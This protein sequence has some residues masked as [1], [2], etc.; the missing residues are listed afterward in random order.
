MRHIKKIAV[1]ILAGTA[2]TALTTVDFSTGAYAFGLK[3]LNPVSV[4][5]HVDPPKAVGAVLA[6]TV[7]VP[8]LAP[9]GEEASG[10]VAGAIVGGGPGAAAGAQGGALLDQAI[11]QGRVPR[12]PSPFSGKGSPPSFF[13]D[14]DN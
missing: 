12:V 11:H 5:R 3:D 2:V 1:A 7:V 13:D 14:D 10:A 4:I 6:P 8:M 9:H